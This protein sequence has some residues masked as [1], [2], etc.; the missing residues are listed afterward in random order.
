MFSPKYEILP[1]KKS[2]SMC[3]ISLTLGMTD[4][5]DNLFKNKYI[6][7]KVCYYIS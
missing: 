2:L 3:G 5:D 4:I 1:R 6:Y 7:F